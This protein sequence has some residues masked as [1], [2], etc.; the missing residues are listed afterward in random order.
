MQTLPA[1]SPIGAASCVTQGWPDPWRGARARAHPAD[2]LPSTQQVTA[3]GARSPRWARGLNSVAALNR[4]R[5]PLLVRQ[6]LLENIDRLTRLALGRERT[7]VVGEQ[8]MTCPDPDVKTA[9]AAQL[10]AARLLGVDD[11]RE[12]FL[13]LDTRQ[14]DDLV[15]QAR[16][17][18]AAQKTPALP[19][20]E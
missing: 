6:S 5:D 19:A 16:R 13:A 11:A 7:R 1:P 4:Q 18:L 20:K 12:V 15:A 2:T 17:A 10:A 3:R 9:L 14:L 8:L